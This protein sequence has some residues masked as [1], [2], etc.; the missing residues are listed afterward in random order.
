MLDR[1]FPERTAVKLIVV[2]D[3]IN[4][5]VIIKSHSRLLNINDCL[6]WKD[7]V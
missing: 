7:K 4:K 5:L 6:K 2:R 3:K 1:N